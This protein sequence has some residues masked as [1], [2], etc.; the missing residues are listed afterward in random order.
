MP[1][2][3]VMAVLTIG[4]TAILCI[5]TLNHFTRSDH[6][7][8]WLVLAGLPL[9]F[10]VNQFIKTPAITSLAAWTGIPLRLAPDAPVWFIIA[11]WLNAPV[12]EE[13]IKLLPLSIPA[14]RVFLCD[15]S[16]A[17]YAGLALGMGFG[18]GEA[19]YLAYGIGQSPAYN[20]LPWHMF[21][22][23]ASER[24]IVTFA[25]GLMTSIAVLGFYG[26]RRKVL[27][28]YLTAVG[29]HALINLG[30]ILLV[31][32]FI[33]ATVANLASY[34]AIL[35]AFLIFQKNER[36]AKQISGIVP[37]EIVYFER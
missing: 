36:A 2:I 21:R 27:T 22:G 12:F 34:A 32:K 35:L 6:R 24:L 23:F 25:H 5:A 1:G 26:G 29:L 33:P 18:L 4:L 28:G 15:A 17:L 30:P 16:Q 3:Y 9:S 31:L 7:Y 11:I 10:I 20:Q 37:K 13:A 8:F 19:A 14:S